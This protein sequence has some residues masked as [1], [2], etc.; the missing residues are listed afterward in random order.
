MDINSAFNSGLRGFQNANQTAARSAETIARRSGGLAEDRT[1]ETAL[2]EAVTA[3]NQAAAATQ[4]VRA[5]DET[6]GSLIDTRA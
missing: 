3:E 4:V 5:A 1:V 6:S 2:V